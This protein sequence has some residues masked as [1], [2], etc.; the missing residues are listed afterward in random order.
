MT[1]E[2]FYTNWKE[3][4]NKIHW[5]KKK[6]L[7]IA[8]ALLVLVFVFFLLEKNNSDGAESMTIQLQKYDERIVAVGQLQLTKETTLVSEI[9]GEVIAVAAKEG[10]TVSAGA[11]I[12]T[13]ADLDRDYQLEQKKAD[14]LDADAQYKHLIEY[15]YIAAKEDLNRLAYQKE[16]EQ[17][18]YDAAASLY[19]EGALSESEYL[20]YQSSYKA[21][22]AQWNTAKLKVQALAEGGTL[23]TSAYSQMQSAQAIYDS[24]LKDGEKYTISAPW[25][26]VL[27]KAYVSQHDYV[28]PGDALADIGEA[29]NYHVVT[30]LDEKYFPYLIKG[31]KATISLGD[32]GNGGD[33]EGSVDV[34]TPKINE[35]TGTFQVLISLPKEFPYQ[36]SD[37]TV[38]VEIQI[39]EKEDAV[40]IPQQ[41]VIAKES[42]V[43]L[44]QNGKAVKTEIQYESGISSDVLVKEGLNE[45]DVIIRPGVGIED[46]KTL[47]ISKGDGAS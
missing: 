2:R 40:V 30:E 24:A 41:Y 21:I 14:Y 6:V 28:Q 45:G 22:V 34:I 37:L 16:Q 9:S 27:L 42:S 11:I 8:F 25:N 31:M 39:E 32:G 7:A 35:E 26:S 15:D 44:Y 47:E 17:K 33:A 36:A 10:D 13:I 46:G 4:I 38:N 23:R 29:G 12:I 20:E 3:K 5:T 19:A 18:S 43:Y 1:Q